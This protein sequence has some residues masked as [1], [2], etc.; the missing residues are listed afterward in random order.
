MERSSLRSGCACAKL[1]LKWG[2]VLGRRLRSLLLV[3]PLAVPVC[4]LLV[5][6][7]VGY[8]QSLSVPAT[9]LEYSGLDPITATP[10]AYVRTLQM[11]PPALSIDPS[12]V[13]TVVGVVALSAGAIVFVT[14]LLFGGRIA[15]RA[16]GVVLMTEEDFPQVQGK[17]RQLSARLGLASPKVG[18]V[19][20]LRP[21]AFSLGRGRGAHRILSWDTGCVGGGGA[22]GS[23][24]A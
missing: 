21:N 24:L 17:V 16:F 4:A 15:R 8:V 10:D 13:L 5:S 3:I 19:E 12:V 9:F 1:L 18:L 6:Y 2:D 11:A 22:G 7:V 23:D 20:D 14:T